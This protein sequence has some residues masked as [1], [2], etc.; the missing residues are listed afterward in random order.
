[1]KIVYLEATEKAN[2]FV[3]KEVDGEVEV[4]SCFTQTGLVNET[5]DSYFGKENFID[6]ESADDYINSKILVNKYMNAFNSIARNYFKKAEMRDDNATCFIIPESLTR[7]EYGPGSYG[8]LVGGDEKAI[9][10]WIYKNIN[11]NEFIESYEENKMVNLD[12]TDI[13]IYKI[14]EDE[15]FND[16]YE[17]EDMIENKSKELFAL[18]KSIEDV[19]EESL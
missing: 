17:V 6:N 15:V 14:D 16:N 11:V 9:Y 12:V 10:L 8:V 4:I 19:I 7:K 1:M 3:K 13:L 18:K 2:A 5:V